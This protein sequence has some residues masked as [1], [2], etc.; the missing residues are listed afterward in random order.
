MPL[1]GAAIG[2]QAGL[3]RYYGTAAVFSDPPRRQ[4][5]WFPSDGLRGDCWPHLMSADDA[6]RVLVTIF[7]VVPSL[8][9]QVADMHVPA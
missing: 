4:A 8:R 3:D 1:V 9:R 2:K 7:Q 5:E 6:P